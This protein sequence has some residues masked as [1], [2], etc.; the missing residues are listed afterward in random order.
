MHCVR[1]VTEDLWWVGGSDRRLSRFE[2]IHPLPRG[3]S[4]NSYL[5]LD[6]QTVLFDTVD[7]AIGRQFLENVKYAL[8]ERPLNYLI[9]N[10]VEPDHAAAIE[11]ILIRWPEVRIITTAKSVQMMGQFGFPAGECTEVVKEGDT[12]CFGKHHVTF[13]SAPMVHWP[14]VMVTFD[15][16]DGVLFSAD[17]FGTFNA[18]NGV[19]FDDEVDF[20]RDWMEGARRYYTNIVGKYGGQV[21]TLLKKLS[22]L[23]IRY[24]CSLHGP[25]WRS[26][27]PT[28]LEKYDKWSSYT[29]EE[30]GI[31]IVYASMYGNTEAAACAVA[32][33]LAERGI[34]NFSMYDVSETH[35][36]YLIAESFRYSHIVLACVTYNLGIY[37]PMLGYLED[38][39]A[40]N[41]QN[42]TFALVENGS[43]ARRSGDLMAQFLSGMKNM[44]VLDPRLT[45]TS[46]LGK[47]CAPAVDSFVDTI[48]A[49]LKED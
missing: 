40:L 33:A 43:W 38:M 10:H 25:V 6:E 18:L 23:S 45:I 24:I 30:N 17:A 5:L 39:K 1:K 36:S 14:E 13:Y 46:S 35:V 47:D 15:E 44:P 16:T 20:E 42:R 4:Y 12:R 26:N 27:I 9:I 21:Q 11:E 48:L 19:L 7:W 8:G 29:P 31:L 28:I 49:S 37:P 41:L 22:G 3:I 32:S 34:T 2:N